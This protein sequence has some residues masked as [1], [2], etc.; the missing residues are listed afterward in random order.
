M[1]ILNNWSLVAVHLISAAWPYE[2]WDVFDPPT[3]VFNFEQRY[4]EDTIIDFSY[5]SRI[6]CKTLVQSLLRLFTTSLLEVVIYVLFAV[7]LAINSS[8]EKF[9][10]KFAAM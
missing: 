7:V 5:L 3:V 6:G 2:C 1:I 8:K 9:L 4:P 10:D